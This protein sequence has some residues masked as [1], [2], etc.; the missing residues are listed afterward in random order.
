MPL[1]QVQSGFTINSSDINQIVQV[2]QRP[3]GSQETG[4]YFLTQSA[5]GAAQ[6]FGEYVNSLSRNSTPGGSV[7]I[8]TSD[9]APSNCASPTADHLTANGFRV[10]TTSTQSANTVM[11]GGSYS[12]AY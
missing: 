12:I 7:S 1:Y 5:S 11:V 3:A 9:Q 6:S 2:L 4:K 8:D 10:A